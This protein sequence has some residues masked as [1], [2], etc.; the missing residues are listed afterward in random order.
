[1]KKLLMMICIGVITLTVISPAFAQDPIVFTESSY[2]EIAYERLDLYVD[3]SITPVYV[4]VTPD[5]FD[6]ITEII[7][8]L[9][10]IDNDIDWDNFGSGAA[11]ANGSQ[12]MR[13]N[14]LCN[15]YKTIGDLLRCSIERC[16][17]K[18]DKN[19]VGNHL[20][21]MIDFTKYISGIGL[22]MM[23]NHALG[24]IIRDDIT[25]KCE[26]FELL[27]VGWKTI[28]LEVEFTYDFLEETLKIDNPLKLLTLPIVLPMALI[29]TY[30]P[31]YIMLGIFMGTMEIMGVLFMWKRARY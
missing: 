28:H 6:Y 26:N 2:R 23:D 21:V 22:K 11:L 27:V 4:N 16:L 9:D 31:I 19:P 5:S 8:Y 18:D 14:W 15:T 7:F 1:M 25:A 30:E 17:V 29:F 3:G 20:G 13:D 12:L 24:V 10:W